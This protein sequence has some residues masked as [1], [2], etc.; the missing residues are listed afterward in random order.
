MQIKHLKVT[1]MLFFHNLKFNKNSM[2]FMCVRSQQEVSQ[3]SL[4][5]N[6]HALRAQFRSQPKEA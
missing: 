5:S 3:L 4:V 6:A 1:N 2:V